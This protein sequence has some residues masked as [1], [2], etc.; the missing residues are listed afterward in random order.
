MSRRFRGLAAWCALKAY[1]RAGY[2]ALVERCVDHAV[3]FA[4]WIAGTPGLELMNAERMATTP[5]NVVCFR[6]VLA[7]MD[8]AA[9]DAMNRAGVA[10]IQGDGRVF[11]T[12]T[13]WNGRAAI[14]AAFDNWATTEADVA[15]LYD[16]VSEVG[17]RLRGG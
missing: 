7:G 14:R 17:V 6:F 11:V 4:R 8:D 2:R 5:L 3:G 13:T 9:A 15:I 10:A 16:V 1:G 12:G